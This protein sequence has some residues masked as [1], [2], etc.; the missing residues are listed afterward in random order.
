MHGK[1][2]KNQAYY[3][4]TSFVHFFI[5]I[6]LSKYELKLKTMHIFCPLNSFVPF[7]LLQIIANQRHFFYKLNCET[8]I[9]KNIWKLFLFYF[10]YENLFHNFFFPWFEINSRVLQS[11]Y[12]MVEVLELKKDKGRYINISSATT[13]EQHFGSNPNIIF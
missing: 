12:F 5:S 2:E 9:Y 7:N 4:T 6:V 1:C 13:K 8:Q 11:F 10:T 3:I